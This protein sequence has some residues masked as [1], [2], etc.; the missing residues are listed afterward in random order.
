[1]NTLHGKSADAGRCPA[2]L[3]RISPY[4]TACC[5]KPDEGMSVELFARARNAVDRAVDG[6]RSPQLLDAGPVASYA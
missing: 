4:C 1:M 3:G 5:G 2:C 6:F